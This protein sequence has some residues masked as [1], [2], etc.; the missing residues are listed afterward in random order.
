MP[1]AVEAWRVGKLKDMRSASSKN[2]SNFGLSSEDSSTGAY[3][4]LL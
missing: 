1:E 3:L 2:L 4:K